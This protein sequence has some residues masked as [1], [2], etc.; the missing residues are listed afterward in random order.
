MGIGYP[1]DVV[2]CSAL[3][4]DM[5]DSVYPTRTARFGVALI[6]T[7]VLRLK[8]SSY[9]TDYQPLDPECSCM[10]CKKY[11]RAFLHPLVARNI[12]FA[13]NL[14]SYHNVAF[15]QRLAEEIREAIKKGRMD[16]YVKETVKRHY[17]KEEDIPEW[18]REGCTLA[19][20]AL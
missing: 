4:A 5:Y 11:T 7:G 19:S 8:T 17:P 18:V 9:A 10:V 13:S 2:I 3:G 1:L 16:E 14:I 15:M 12:A 6:S 20:I